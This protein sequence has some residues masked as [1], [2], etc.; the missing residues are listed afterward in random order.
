VLN[1]FIQILLVVIILLGQISDKFAIASMPCAGESGGVMSMSHGVMFDNAGSH[2]AISH[3]S[4]SHTDMQHHKSAGKNA[5]RGHDLMAKYQIMD[6]DCC[7]K[8]CCC[9]AGAVS[10][11]ALIDSK[12]ATALDFKNTQ[13]ESIANGLYFTFLAFPKQP[14]KPFYSPVG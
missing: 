2:E 14:P 10:V 7:D 12:L 8:D 3:E 4:M 6:E 11:A 1:R 5:L 13:A 9:P